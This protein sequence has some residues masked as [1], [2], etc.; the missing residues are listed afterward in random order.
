MSY[1]MEKY[2]QNALIRVPAT[3]S[4]EVKDQIDEALERLQIE[5]IDEYN[6]VGIL[7]IY[8]TSDNTGASLDAQL[9]MDTF[10][11]LLDGVVCDTCEIPDGGSEI[12][13]LLKFGGVMGKL[14]GQRKLFIFHYVG[15]AIRGSTSSRLELTPRTGNDEGTLDFSAVKNMITKNAL[16][17]AGLDVLF[18]GGLSN[19]REDGDTFTQDLSKSFVRLA[20]E[21]KQ[22][23]T[24]DLMDAINALSGIEQY[25][26]VFVLQE[27]WKL[28]VTFRPSNIL[29]AIFL[30]L[31]RSGL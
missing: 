25:G 29:S 14:S 22:F 30:G 12:D 3:N 24:F 20:A 10:S 13:I 4:A 18:I 5:S 28:P 7:S 31:H 23:T 15:H 27:G 1:D 2:A 16:R 19:S 26:K 9:F 21:K 11:G 8:W 6:S 17:T